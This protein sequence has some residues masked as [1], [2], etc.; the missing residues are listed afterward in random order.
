MILLIGYGNE[1]RGDDAVGPLVAR[2]LAELRLPDTQVLALTQLTPELA[3]LVSQAS[4]A[5]F[6]DAALDG[7]AG[8]VEVAPCQPLDLRQPL[9]HLGDPE[10]LL[11]LCQAVFG[12]SPSAWMVKVQVETTELGHPLSHAAKRGVSA[13]VNVITRLVGQLGPAC[14][15]TGPDERSD[16]RPKE[17]K[18]V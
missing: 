1:L 8:Q 13:A 9:G 5:I 17:D 18:A 6:V 7:P 11:A 14:P 3:E 2:A 16:H 10:S 15:Q 4:T 12:A